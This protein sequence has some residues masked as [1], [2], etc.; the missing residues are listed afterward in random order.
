MNTQ[1][2]KIVA[3]SSCDLYELA[4][5]PFAVAPLKI[6]TDEKEYVDDHA[7]DVRRMVNDL[8]AYK[9]KSSTSCPNPS[10]WLTAFGDAS[11]V[12]CVTITGTLSGSYNAAVIAK[13]TYEEMYPDRQVFVMQ[14]L[15]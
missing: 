10:D 1:R 7:L 13:Q 12:I 9:G 6:I 2:I 5:A 4:E 14:S 3:D 15:K 8:Q 11:Q